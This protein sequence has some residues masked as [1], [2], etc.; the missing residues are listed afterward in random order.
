MGIIIVMIYHSQ[1]I[2]CLCRASAIARIPYGSLIITNAKGDKIRSDVSRKKTGLWFSSEQSLSYLDGTFPGDFG[3]DPLGLSDPDGKC[4]ALS[5]SW[6]QYAE[7]IHA[8][9]A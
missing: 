9:W 6:L 4:F 2:I 3:F 7:V 1:K 5:P 8:R